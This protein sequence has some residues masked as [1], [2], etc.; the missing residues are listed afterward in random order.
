MG[1]W[2]SLDAWKAEKMTYSSSAILKNLA[3]RFRELSRCGQNRIVD[4]LWNGHDVVRVRME[5][6]VKRMKARR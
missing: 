4:G 5:V 2:V 1:S 6:K 3:D